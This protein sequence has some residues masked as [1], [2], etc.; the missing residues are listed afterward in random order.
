MQGQLRNHRGESVGEKSS[1]GRMFVSVKT[2]LNTVQEREEVIC[3]G[4]NQ[5]Q[6]S[7][8]LLSE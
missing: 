1:L 6:R 5:G 4:H 2:V 7:D 3:S 8:F